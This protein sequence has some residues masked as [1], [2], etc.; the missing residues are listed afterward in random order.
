MPKVTQQV[1]AVDKW[2]GEGNAASSV[3]SGYFPNRLIRFN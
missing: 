3:H 1:P 2:H